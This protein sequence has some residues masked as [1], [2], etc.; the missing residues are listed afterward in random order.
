MNTFV[1]SDDNTKL[2]I[3]LSKMESEDLMR[4][5]NIA[6]VHLQKKDLAELAAGLTYDLDVCIGSMKYCK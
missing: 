4:I 5:L 3:E 1:R 2:V 6:S